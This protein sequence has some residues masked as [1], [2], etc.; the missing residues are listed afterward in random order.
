MSVLVGSFR[1]EKSGGNIQL[2][3]YIQIW[4]PRPSRPQ[5]VAGGMFRERMM[6]GPASPMPLGEKL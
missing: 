4:R 1:R 5:R 6:R 2:S 3:R